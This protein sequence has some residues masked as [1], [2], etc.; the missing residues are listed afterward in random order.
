MP[1]YAE[2]EAMLAPL[3]RRHVP[4]PWEPSLAYQIDRRLK[5]E[6]GR[7]L[8]EALLTASGESLGVLVV[9]GAGGGKTWTVRRTLRRHP[10]LMGGSEAERFVVESTVP[11]GATYKSMAQQLL[12]DSGYAAPSLRRPG[13]DMW[14]MFRERMRVLKTAVLWIDEA[15]DLLCK[16]RETVLPAVKSLMQG[17]GA[18]VVILSGTE[19]LAEVVHSD[20]QVRRR[21]S[22]VRIP[23]LSAEASRKAFEVV[24][25]EYCAIVGLREALAPDIFGRLALASRQRFGRAAVLIVDAIEQALVRG[26][27]CLGIDHFADAYELQEGC[28]PDRNVFLAAGWTAIDPDVDPAA[29]DMP[30]RHRRS[31]RH[32]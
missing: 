25:A 26:D 10:A 6:G 5:H 22:H 2:I 12:A 30:T 15:H 8:P 20:P 11:S 9:A 1:A 21:F 7:I 3:R 27:A 24:I 18:A 4:A 29:L 31:R 23:T 14:A 16:D 13:W 19:A 17:E 28:E 32:A